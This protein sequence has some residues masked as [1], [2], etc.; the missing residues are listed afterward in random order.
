M[1]YEVIM[2]L[3]TFQV[4]NS[5]LRN[6]KQTIGFLG[7]SIN[8]YAYISSLWILFF[9]SLLVIGFFVLKFIRAN[10][11]TKSSKMILSNLED[12]YEAF[13]RASRNNFV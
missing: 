10:E 13:R 9:S 3:K 8:K 11:I 2:S 7:M 6:D 1:L 4:E 5:E 12:E